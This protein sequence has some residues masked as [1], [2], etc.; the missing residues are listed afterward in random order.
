MKT[1]GRFVK[2][3]AKMVRLA[4]RQLIRATQR[5][6]FGG[7]SIV[8][9]KPKA[10]VPGIGSMQEL[11]HNYSVILFGLSIFLLDSTFLSSSAELKHNYSVVLFGLSIFLLDS[12]FLS[13]SA[14]PLQT[15]FGIVTQ[16]LFSIS[17]YTQ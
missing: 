17:M 10:G 6:E 14:V 7:P 2:N 3:Y 15:V 13:S 5:V 11:K 16:T 1:E 12:T 4:L 8:D 9:K